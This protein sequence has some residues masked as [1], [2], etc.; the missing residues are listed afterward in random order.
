MKKHISGILAVTAVAT[1][2]TGAWKLHLA[3]EN[4]NAVSVLERESTELRSRIVTLTSRHETDAARATAIESDN[5][6][7]T[8]E[9]AKVKAADTTGTAATPPV[10]QES[11]E[12]R[13]TAAQLAQSGNADDALRELLWCFDEGVR[14]VDGPRRSSRR[15]VI[16][17]ALAQL[18]ERHPAANAALRD[19]WAEARVRLLQIGNVDGAV[20]DFAL[21]SQILNEKGAMTSLYDQLPKGDTRRSFVSIYA[22]EE[23]VEARRYED[24]LEGRNFSTM[25]SSFRISSGMAAQ[26]VRNHAVTTAAKNVE[27]LAGG[28]QLEHARTLSEQ[29][30]AFDPSP[31]TRE[32]LRKHLERAGH[33]QIYKQLYQSQ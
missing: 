1:A 10:T 16:A 9:L 4:R 7:L 30:L 20:A 18:G 21:L 13:I 31:E 26:P 8:A 12:K 25:I 14:R 3:G 29:V 19:R 33:I 2:A 22:F 24:A 28:G 17:Q 23:L 11:I 27:V 5:A 6:L 15:R 32:I